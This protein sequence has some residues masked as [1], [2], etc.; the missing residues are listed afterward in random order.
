[1]VWILER[2]VQR[3]ICFDVIKHGPEVIECSCGRIYH[4]SWRIRV[5]ECPSC[6]YGYGEPVKEL[7]Q[8]SL[9]E[10]FKDSAE[11]GRK[12]TGEDGDS[13]PID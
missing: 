7:D 10:S 5:E 4:A 3:R 9:I 12:G 8:D 1:M 13:S 6:G 2:S 11:G